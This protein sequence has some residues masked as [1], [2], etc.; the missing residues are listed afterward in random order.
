[1]LHRMCRLRVKR[2]VRMAKKGRVPV[3]H[4]EEI[5]VQEFL[6]AAQ[7]VYAFAD[8]IEAKGKEL[9]ESLAKDGAEEAQRAFGPEIEVTAEDGTITARGSQVVFREFGAGKGTVTDDPFPNA[10][11]P[12]EVRDGSYS[13]AV[14]GPYARSGYK[15]WTHGGKFY[16]RIEPVRGMFRAQNVMISKAVKKAKEIFSDMTVQD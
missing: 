7:Q 2:V 13:D 16:D 9:A 10:P 4:V 8:Q 15:G 6:K 11:L 3:I 14:N 12:F 5:G 1:M